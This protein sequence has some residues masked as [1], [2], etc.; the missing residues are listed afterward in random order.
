[1]VRHSTL[2]LLIA[3]SDFADQSYSEGL[4]DMFRQSDLLLIT[5]KGE[6]LPGLIGN[7]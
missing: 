2:H 4:V 1:M 6:T 5:G 7:D 3:W